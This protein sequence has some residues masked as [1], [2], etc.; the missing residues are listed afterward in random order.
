MK[1]P[2][3]MADI[4]NSR[5][6]DSRLLMMQ[7][8]KVV[9][10]TNKTFQKELLSPLTI[11]LGDEFQ[12]ITNSIESGIQVIFAI[13]E[14]IIKYEFDIKLRYVLN[15]GEIDTKVN[16]K[17]AYEMLGTGLTEARDSLNN[18]KKED[19][20][21]LIKL[22]DKTNAGYYVNRMFLIY[23]SIVDSWKPKDLKSVSEFLIYGDYKKVA[24]I[25]R[26]DASSAWRRKK[27][28]KIN[29][30]NSAK[31]IILFLATN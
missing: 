9:V 25:I 14:L 21:F 17:V 27:S 24:K 3:L 11:T 30:F 16:K 26:T 1:Y 18:L 4:E 15:F 8:K 29:E 19:A 7:F 10:R 23:Q 31:E 28:L 13:E 20:R 5:D 22:G 6:K 12:G 2:I